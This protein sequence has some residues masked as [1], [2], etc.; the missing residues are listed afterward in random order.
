MDRLNH[1]AS[2]LLPKDM[3]SVKISP[4]L[5]GEKWLIYMKSWVLA[6]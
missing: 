3:R 2:T 1:C 4:F 6:H 5:G